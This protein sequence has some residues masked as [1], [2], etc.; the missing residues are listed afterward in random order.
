MPLLYPW[1]RLSEGACQ[2]RVGYRRRES[3]ALVEAR[4]RRRSGVDDEFVRKVLDLRLGERELEALAQ[5]LRG[6]DA[7]RE[8]GQVR[9]WNG[10]VSATSCEVREEG[11]QTLLH[12]L[13]EGDDALGVLPRVPERALEKRLELGKLLALEP[14]IGRASCR[15]RVS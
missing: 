13:D 14:E 1:N 7:V 12:E 15:E 6:E 11:E 3:D 9:V 8:A 4:E 5:L 2:Y 10:A